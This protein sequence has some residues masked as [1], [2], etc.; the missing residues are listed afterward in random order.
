MI[1]ADLHIHSRFS[2]ATSHQL[3]LENLEKYAKIKGVD[4]L[5]T[6]DFMHPEW[7]KELKEN[8]T[9]KQGILYSKTGFPFVLQTE[10]SFMYTQA[11]KGRRVHLVILAPSFEVTDKITAYFK[12]FGR[13]DYDGRP[14]FGRD[15][16]TITRD[17]KAISNDIEIIPAHIWTPWF[18]I[19]GSKSGFNSLKEAFGDQIKHIHAIET[20]LSSDPPMNWRISE[21]DNFTIISCSDLHSF[22]PW[23]LGREA[24]LF[25]FPELTYTNIIKAI[26]TGEGLIGTVEVDPAY[27]KYHYDGHRNCGISFSPQQ[28][29]EHNNTCPVCKRPLTIGVEN[30]VE[31]LADRPE[32]YTPPNPKKFYRL[33]PISE[34]IAA[35]N[36]GSVSSK[37]TWEVFNKLIE[38]FGNEYNILL[39]VP[40]NE[41]AD[42][43][44][45]QL[46]QVLIDNRDGKIKVRPGFDGVYGVALIKDI[47]DQPF[48][49]TGEKTLAKKESNQPQTRPQKSLMDY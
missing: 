12:S 47:P 28:S 7:I 44:G 16:M 14:I 33:M 45:N 15:V 25:D 34:L 35:V 18:G 31:E 2:R 13:V 32:G 10:I 6:G 22:W 48:S 29:K 26:R 19:L 46:A 49:G 5:G 40:L 4:V 30:R 11:G 36:G 37:K 23:R 27:G 24:T 43:V 20:G 8:L 41:L 21:I 39:N 3:N 38:S 42:V 17:L 1:I 9:E